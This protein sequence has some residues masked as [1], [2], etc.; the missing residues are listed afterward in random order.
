MSLRLRAVAAEQPEPGEDGGHDDES[1]NEA[2]DATATHSRSMHYIT[3][4]R[5]KRR[6]TRPASA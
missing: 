2:Q 4:P 3:I 1:H 5:E 6:V